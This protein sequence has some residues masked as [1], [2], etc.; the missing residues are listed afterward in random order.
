[1]SA[2]SHPISGYKG[3]IPGLPTEETEGSTRFFLMRAK[4]SFSFYKQNFISISNIRS[5]GACPARL[6]MKIL[7]TVI[8]FFHLLFSV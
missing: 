7:T 4:N 2:I 3:N 1:M 6:H 5:L 8:W